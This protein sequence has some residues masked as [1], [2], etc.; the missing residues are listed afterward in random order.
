MSEMDKLK[1]ESELGP[2]R[3]EVEQLQDELNTLKDKVFT[4]VKRFI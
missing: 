3:G 4:Y 2:D 1:E